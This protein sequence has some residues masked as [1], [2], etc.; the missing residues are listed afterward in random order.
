MHSVRTRQRR[1]NEAIASQL[2]EMRRGLFLASVNRK[3]KAYPM[4][5]MDFNIIP[6][7]FNLVSATFL[8]LRKLRHWAVLSRG[9]RDQHATSR[10]QS[11]QIPPFSSVNRKGKAYPMG[12][13]DFNIIYLKLGV[14]LVRRYRGDRRT[15]YR[16]LPRGRIEGTIHQRKQQLRSKFVHTV[17][18][19]EAGDHTRA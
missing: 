4:G 17:G 2:S 9:K 7:G 18:R 6:L 11:G 5:P 14:N 19:I 15:L 13:M 10:G 1:W 16:H 12:P 3:G 8:D